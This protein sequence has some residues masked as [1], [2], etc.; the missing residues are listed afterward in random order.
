MSNKN[1]LND[2][3]EPLRVALQLENEG[4]E[5][6]LEAARKVS[7]KTAHQTFEFLAAEEEK[8]I[9]RIGEFYRSLEVTDGT[10]VPE[11]AKSDA[12]VRLVEFNNRLAELQNEIRPTLSDIEAYRTAL[13]FENGA[14]E[15]YARQIKESDDPNIRKFYQ[16]LIDEEA[17][18]AK[19]ILSCI[20]FAEDPAGWFKA[21]Q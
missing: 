8:H 13:K 10:V 3:L 15:F 7:G 1:N 17:M 2:L 11:T 16:W 20:R 4:R 19:V 12:D 9:R 21:Q 5:F 14:E 6:F 18:H